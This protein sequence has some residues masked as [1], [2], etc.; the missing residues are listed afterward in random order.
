M[1]E[2]TV[3]D[4]DFIGEAEKAETIQREEHHEDAHDELT[5]EEKRIARK[6]MRKIDLR[7][8]PLVILV[9]LMNYIDR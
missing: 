3:K 4:H 8:M 9:Y 7:I 6:L 2:H 5:E 1:A